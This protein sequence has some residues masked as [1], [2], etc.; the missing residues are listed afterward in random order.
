MAK[1]TAVIIA[2]NEADRIEKT[3]SAIS[4]C[5]EIIVVD[6]GSSDQTI[7]VSKNLGCKVYENPFKSFGEQKKFGFDKAVN[8]WILS[9]DADEVMT[10][11]LNAEIESLFENKK[12]HCNGY[13]IRFRMVF[14]N[15]VFRFGKESRICPVRLFDR[16]KAKITDPEIHEKIVVEG[17]TPKLRNCADHYSYRNLTHYFEKFNDYTLKAAARLAG[18]K[19]NNSF[20]LPFLKLHF[21]FLRFYFFNLNF[22][23]GYPGLIWSW[24]SANYFLIK[25]LKAKELKS[26]K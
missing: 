7:K 12:P 2:L 18:K 11:E 16:T 14:L 1:V 8:D 17:G 3:I 21:A 19:K 26:K 10:P 4:C 13:R 5:N 24:L 25:Y 22:L 15:K 6:S 20:H 23:N 9:V